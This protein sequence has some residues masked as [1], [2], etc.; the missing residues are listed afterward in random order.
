MATKSQVKVLGHVFTTMDESDYEG[1]AGAEDGCKICYLDDQV[2]I[3]SPDE[4]EIS[5][6]TASPGCVDYTEVVWTIKN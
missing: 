4:T 1:F 3:L 2:L 5:V 6:I